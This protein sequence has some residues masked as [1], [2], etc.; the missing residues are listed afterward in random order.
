MQIHK[1]VGPLTFQ[2]L[3]EKIL[4]IFTKKCMSGGGG[5]GG[6]GNAPGIHLFVN[7]PRPEEPLMPDPFPS[8]P[9]ERISTD[10]FELKD[11]LL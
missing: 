6:G 1:S 3:Q 5:R 8:C 2:F 10:L 4:L 7:Q 11:T 9:W